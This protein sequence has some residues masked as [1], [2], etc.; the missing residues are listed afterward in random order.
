MIKQHRRGIMTTKQRLESPE[1]R[2]DMLEARLDRMESTLN[3][4]WD[5]L[6][7]QFRRTVGLIFA[8]WTT[9]TLGIA[10]AIL[11]VVITN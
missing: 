6:R 3:R 9:V 11:S 10:G 4:I 2:A 7:S 5:D 8:M 1:Q